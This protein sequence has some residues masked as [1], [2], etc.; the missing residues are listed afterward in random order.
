MAVIPKGLDHRGIGGRAKTVMTETIFR[1]LTVTFNAAMSYVPYRLKYFISTALSR[2]KL[3][4][5][6]IENGDVVI[7]V[8]LP[9]DILR[10]GRSRAILFARLVGTGKV[11]VIEPD[12]DNIAAAKTFIARHKLSSRVMLAECGAWRDKTVLAFL[13]CPSH[14]AANLLRDANAAKSL[15]RFEDKVLKARRYEELAVRVDT[16]DNILCQAGV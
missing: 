1:G 8:G 11:V 4:Y 6:C 5:S 7:Q 10:A 13:S 15:D 9:R 3:P 12:P 16:L 2:S 14:P